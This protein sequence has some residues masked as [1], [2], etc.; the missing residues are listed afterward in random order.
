MAHVVTPNRVMV[1]ID[2]FN[3]YFG[4][5]SKGWKRYY[6]LNLQQMALNLLKPGQTLAGV[7]YFTARITPSPRDPDQF[8]RQG[9]F[10]EAVETLPKTCIFYGHF[11]PKHQKCLNCGATW[12]SHEEKMT[13][14]HIAVEL[15][16][17]GYEDLF[18]T[19]LLISGDS[20][21]APPISTVLN[22][23]PSKR[24][25]VIYPPDRHSAKLNSVASAS[26]TLGRGVLQDSQFPDEVTKSNGFILRRPISWR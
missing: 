1:Y 16:R 15:L 13:D 23:F 4:L 3:L 17:D 10:L 25:V 12:T 7:K 11:L 21:L 19:A 18:D 6:W 5:K 2:G 24:I 20:D 9:V 22:Q 14:V 26:M 8:R